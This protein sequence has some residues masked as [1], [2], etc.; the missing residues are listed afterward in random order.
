[1]QASAS[2]AFFVPHTKSTAFLQISFTILEPFS[3]NKES[4]ISIWVNTLRNVN[5]IPPA[6]I[7]S[8][9]L[10]NICMIMGILSDILAPPSIVRKGF[11]GLCKTLE[12]YFN[13]FAIRKPD[14]RFSKPSP[15]IELWA[16]WAVPNASLTYTSP[17]LAKFFRN[18]LTFSLSAMILSSASRT[19]GDSLHCNRKREALIKSTNERSV[20]PSYR[21]KLITA[22]SAGPRTYN[23]LCLGSLAFCHDLFSKAQIMSP[24]AVFGSQCRNGRIV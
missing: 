18:S 10:S 19:T 12:K 7:M 8:F 13:S 11:G 24:I 9:T 14:A 6:I 22:Q 1:M 4:A 15:I 16:R 23:K 5:A 2:S 20:R 17:N 21:E 3:S